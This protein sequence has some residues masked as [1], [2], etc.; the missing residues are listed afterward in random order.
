[1][2]SDLHALPV[3]QSFVI[4]AMSYF[5][6]EEDRK[7]QEAVVT[8]ANEPSSVVNGRLKMR[9]LWISEDVPLGPLMTR[10]LEASRGLSV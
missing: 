5:L 10:C 7:K 1:M 3:E 8:P 4:V 6:E 2:T 9:Q